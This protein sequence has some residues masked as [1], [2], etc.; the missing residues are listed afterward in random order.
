MKK[1][2]YYPHFNVPS[3]NSTDIWLCKC[4]N[5]NKACEKCVHLVDD[6][7]NLVDSRREILT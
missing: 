2:E 4:G 5:W 3:Y 1:E 6:V 7:G